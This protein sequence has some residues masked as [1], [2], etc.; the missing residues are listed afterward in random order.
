MLY[1]STYSKHRDYFMCLVSC[2]QEVLGETI[3]KSEPS[4]QKAVRLLT[5]G[6]H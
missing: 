5:R 6:G 2:F 3:A 4:A 1:S